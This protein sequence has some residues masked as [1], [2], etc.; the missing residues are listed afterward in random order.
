VVNR[1]R[2]DIYLKPACTRLDA[3]GD[4]YGGDQEILRIDERS[5]TAMLTNCCA[6]LAVPRRTEKE[7]Y[8]RAVRNE[9]NILGGVILLLLEDLGFTVSSRTNYH[10]QDAARLSA[11]Y[12][13]METVRDTD[14]RRYSDIIHN[15]T[16]VFT[17]YRVNGPSP[18]I[19]ELLTLFKVTARSSAATYLYRSP[20]RRDHLIHV[21]RTYA[22]LTTHR[23]S[24]SMG[25]TR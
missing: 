9:V 15:N 1:P 19:V 20:M 25:S 22:E 13:D 2:W 3:T 14:P 24:M 10:I 11:L 18:D 6:M 17:A 23:R 12:P 7:A 16:G 8:S 4:P 21:P 5:I